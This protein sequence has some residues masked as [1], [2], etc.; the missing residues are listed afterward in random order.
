M[1]E[2]SGGIS[3]DGKVEALVVGAGPAGLAAAEVLSAGGLSVV[4]VDAMPSVG[5][6]FLMAGKSGLNLT[7]DEAE[8]AFLARFGDGAEASRGAIEAFGP[9]A[10][11]DWA[12]GLGEEIFTGTT[13]R[14]FPRAM[15]ASPL[16]RR[17]MGRLAEL[18][19]EVRTRW[20]WTGWDGAKFVFS[21]PDGE[22]RISAD[23]AVM[24]LGG[25]SWARL[26]S[27]GVWAEVF[28]TDGI[29]CRGFEASNAGLLVDWSDHM[30]GAFGTPVKGTALRAG[31]V[32]TRGE[33]VISKRGMEG[34]GVYEVTRAVREG[35]ALTVDLVPEWS[36]EE[37]TLKLERPRGK[38]SVSNY[39]RKALGLSSVQR[40]LLM[41]WARPLP[42][43]ADLAAL[44]KAVP[45]PV[46]GLFPLD[47][48]ISTAGG[49][50]WEALDGFMLRARPGVFVAGEMLDWDAPTGG[51]L[52]TGCLATGRAAAA[53]ALAYR[54]A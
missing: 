35:A 42:E 7:K 30:A 25:G 11:Q 52:I 43:G 22:V 5:R 39:L 51:Y 9:E 41:E 16:L 44:V 28:A 2:E 34:G 53:Q 24:A 46:A 48:A 38:M 50:A 27:D 1:S 40:A 10:V 47:E 36:V 32:L 45:V 6:K 54:A 14:V 12:R 26:G 29:D 18:G 4:V 37:V 23:V 13:G 3:R 15:K 33:W 19:V 49:V 8:A 21:T 31:E 20:R 17:W